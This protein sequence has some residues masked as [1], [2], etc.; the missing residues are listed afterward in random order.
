M[1][2]LKRHECLL[3]FE[4]LLTDGVRF[5]PYSTVWADRGTCVLQR[6]AGT[7][8]IGWG[9]RYTHHDEL[10]LALRSQS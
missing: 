4:E 10:A 6:R 9:P 2:P 7:H 3:E 8:L 5:L 1:D